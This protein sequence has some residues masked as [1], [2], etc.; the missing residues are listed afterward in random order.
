MGTRYW[1]CR[2]IFAVVLLG[3][4]LSGCADDSEPGGQTR[5]DADGSEPAGTKVELLRADREDFERIVVAYTAD[6]GK[7]ICLDVTQK[8]GDGGGCDPVPEDAMFVDDDATGGL[9]FGYL[10][11][12]ADVV[13]VRVASGGRE[14]VVPLEQK[15][16]SPVPVH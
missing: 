15:M 7:S 3:A 9:V 8:R 5:A 4:V 12:H 11:G 10:T 13:E 14:I 6:E 16:L 1:W 2:S